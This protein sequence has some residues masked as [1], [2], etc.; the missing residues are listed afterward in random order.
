MLQQFSYMSFFLEKLWIFWY[1]FLKNVNLSNFSIFKITI[2]LYH[3]I[4]TKTM[5][6]YYLAL[7][8]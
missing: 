3:K 4:E 2:F 8:H 6:P 5:I 7:K 1:D